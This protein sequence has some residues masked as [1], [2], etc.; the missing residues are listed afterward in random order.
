MTKHHSNKTLYLTLLT[1]LFACL[2]LAG[3]NDTSKP[4]PKPDPSR[5]L[6]AAKLQ[7]QP[8]GIKTFHFSWDAVE[9]A[10]YYQLL[11]DR[12]DGNTGFEL[13]ADGIAAD[14]AD[15]NGQLHFYQTDVPL[16]ARDNTKY[17]L[18]TCDAPD[19]CVDG[20]LLPIKNNATLNHLVGAIGYVK[21]SNTDGFDDFGVS[22]SLNRAGTVMAVGARAERSKATGINGNQLD[23]SVVTAGAV[24]VYAKDAQG[25][26]Q[27]Q[28]YIKA[29]T[30]AEGDYFGSVVSL[31]ATG[32]VL[33]VAAPYK[34]I[35]LNNQTFD[36]AGAVYLFR[37]DQDEQ[38]WQQMGAA[39]TSANPRSSGRFGRS[40]SLNADGTLLAVGGGD[41]VA[42]FQQD[43]NQQWQQQGEPLNVG[44][45]TD[46]G[47]SVSLNAA[48]TLLAAGAPSD[49]SIASEAGAVYLFGPG[50]PGGTWLQRG[51]AILNPGTGSIIEDR[52]GYSVSLNAEGNLLAVSSPFEDSA[53]T[54]VDNKEDDEAAR[55]S[56]A[57][58]VYAFTT[59]QQWE[60]RAYIKASNT[61][62]YNLF[63]GI[64]SLSD[65]GQRLLVGTGLSPL[66]NSNSGTVNNTESGSTVGLND[67]NDNNSGETG[68]EFSGAAYSYIL[69]GNN[70]WQFESYIKASNTGSHDHFGIVLDLSGDGQ[71]LAVGAFEE[72]SNGKGVGGLDGAESQEQGYDPLLNNDL[73]QAGAVYLY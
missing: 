56:G 28:T 22:V 26:W 24:Y 32:K 37:Y 6:T 4:K 34:T 54:L 73:L 23:N 63:G 13:L 8:E 60:K 58:Y 43:G 49:S 72:D 19:H 66:S 1:V 65:D 71:T 35:T 21:A 67:P 10:T 31:N 5:A 48:G 17:L 57:A 70:K 20:Q 25:A 68:L 2:A 36:E 11:E 18:R 14:E 44:Q 53:S 41:S 51:D 55:N 69:G 27:Q 50:E 45:N 62:V 46:F 47:R 61:D 39:L 52:F 7:L 15:N 59:N 64:V 33:A 38:E 40:L 3:C 42:L 29:D 12:G 9:D 30:V 16:Y